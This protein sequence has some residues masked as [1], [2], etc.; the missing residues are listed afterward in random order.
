MLPNG[1]ESWF[2]YDVGPAR[3]VNIDLTSDD[4][5]TVVEVWRVPEDARS[6]GSMTSNDD[7]GS[8][9]NSRLSLSTTANTV[10]LV[11]VRSFGSSSGGRFSLYV[12]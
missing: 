10:L 5:D 8:G 4:F 11:K 2:V 12:R 1:G 6:I 9:R 7:G 3:Q